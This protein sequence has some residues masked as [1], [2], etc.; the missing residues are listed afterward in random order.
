M[1]RQYV[2]NNKKERERLIKLVNEISDKELKLVIY[3]EGW[4][5]AAMLGHLAFWDLRRLELVKR[6]RQGELKRSDIDG[7]NM[8]TV[9][10]A[11]VP[12]FL[13]LPPRKLADLAVSAAEALD[14]ALE[15]LPVNLL[16]AIKAMGDRNAL[17]RGIHRKMHLD[18]I[19]ALL[20]AK[21]SKK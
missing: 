13:E 6:W 1:E 5:V 8:H 20:K 3:K 14:R 7:I 10:D 18:E 4:T 16:P 2:I 11:L 17:N 15:R 12:F 21:R 19:D 9:N